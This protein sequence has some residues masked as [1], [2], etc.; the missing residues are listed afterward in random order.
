MFNQKITRTQVAIIA[1]AAMLVLAGCSTGTGGEPTAVPAPMENKSG[2]TID[3]EYGPENGQNLTEYS[4]DLGPDAA[5]LTR[6]ERKQIEDM[7]GGFYDDLP[8]NTSER[9]DLFLDTADEHCAFEENY[10]SRV[11]TSALE[12]NG[13]DMGDTVRRMHYGAQIGNEFDSQVPVEPFADIR[14]ETGD[15]TKYAPLLGS[16]NQMSEAACAASEDRTDAAIQDYQFATLM[17]GVDAMLISTGAFYQPAFAGTRFTANKASQLGLY[18]LRYV[19]GDRC[20]A[21]AMSEVHVTLRGSMVSGTSNLLRQAEEMD[22]DLNREDLEAIAEEHDTDVDSML[23]DVDSSTASDVLDSVSD[24]ATA[25]RDAVLESG[26]GGSSGDGGDG[27]I[28]GGD[29]IDKDDIVE[30]GEDALNKSAQAVEDCRDAG[31]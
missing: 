28:F 22:A 27:G 18:R 19:C 16:Y 7:V 26:D 5:G 13:S 21:L 9:R 25:C 30:K 14:S 17:F 23:E 31:G 12:E 8:E 15:V 3:L 1:V 2:E 29:G 24:D 10:S 4:N 6:S 20:W 11:N